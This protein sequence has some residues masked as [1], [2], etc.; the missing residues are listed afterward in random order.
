MTRHGAGNGAAATCAI[1]VISAGVREAI[2]TIV[3]IAARADGAS[4]LAFSGRRS[5]AHRRWP[6]GTIGAGAAG[7]TPTVGALA[8]PGGG[9]AA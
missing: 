7:I 1:P 3:H 2:A 8:D 5:T 6:T 9:A 4:R